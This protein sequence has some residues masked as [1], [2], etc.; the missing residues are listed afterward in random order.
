[1][2]FLRLCPRVFR[3]YTKPAQTWFIP[4]VF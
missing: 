2:L 3:G 4:V 1:M